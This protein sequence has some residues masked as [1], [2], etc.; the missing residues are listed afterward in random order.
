MKKAA[1][2]RILRILRLAA[3]ADFPLGSTCSHHGQSA[4][5]VTIGSKF[6]WLTIIP[7]GLDVI[8]VPIYGGQH[9]DEFS[10][11]FFGMLDELVAE[12]FGP[13]LDR[14][15]G[16]DRN[17]G[18]S[19]MFPLPVKTFWKA[20]GQYHSWGAKVLGASPKLVAEFELFEAAWAEAVTA[21]EVIVDGGV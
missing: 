16:Q 15:N 8:T 4:G 5:G 2:G 20:V 1:L 10:T 12:V 13:W 17:S 9:S 3:K 19:Y 7:S 11:E 6:V 14:W 21:A 18:V